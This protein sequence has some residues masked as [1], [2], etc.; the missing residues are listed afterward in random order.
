MEPIT[1]YN[2]F[3]GTAFDKLRLLDGV[4]PLLLRLIVAPVMM[5]AG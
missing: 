2:R 4:V 5:Q 3:Y 1:A